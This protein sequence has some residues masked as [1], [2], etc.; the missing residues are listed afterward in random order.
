MARIAFSRCS[1]LSVLNSAKSSSTFP[2]ANVALASFIGETQF[3][4]TA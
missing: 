1:E 3:D 2:H 4:C